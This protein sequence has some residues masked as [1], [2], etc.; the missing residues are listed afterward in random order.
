MHGQF[1]RQTAE[2]ADTK[3]WLWLQKG[4]LKI[5]TESLITAVQ[6]QA[7][8]A[9]L[10]K[11]SQVKP[12]Q[13][14]SQNNPTCRMSKKEDESVMHIISGWSK[15]VQKEYKKRHDNMGKAIHW[16]LCRAKGLNTQKSGLN[17]TQKVS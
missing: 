12:D 10:T 16:D 7:L 17:T 8:R 1:I 5:E 4:Y 6:D 11:T 13:K 9:N 3:S 14:K 15:Q 2:T